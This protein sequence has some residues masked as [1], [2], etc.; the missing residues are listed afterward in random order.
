MK[1][2]N[3][4][5]VLC[6][7]FLI[8]ACDETSSTI[9]MD[10]VPDSDVVTIS[11]ENLDVELN[12]IYADSVL[13]RTSTCHLGNYTDPET[14]SVI[15]GDFLMQLNCGQNFEFPDSILYNTCSE[16]YLRLFFNDFVGDT[17]APCRVSIYPLTKVLDNSKAYYTDIDATEYYDVNAKPIVTTTFTMSDR[18][19][20]DSARYDADSYKNIRLKLP[21]EIGNDIIQKYKTHPE[22]FANGKVFNEKVNSGYFVKFERGDGVMMDIYVSQ[23]NLNYKYFEKSSTGRLDSLA[24]GSTTFAGTEE[25]IQATSIKKLN[26]DKLLKDESATYVKSPSSLFTEITLPIDEISISDTINSAKLIFDRF[27]AED[28]DADYTLPAPNYLLLVAKDKM[29]SFFEENSLPDSETSYLGTFST[30]NNNYVFSNIAHLLTKLRKE[31]QEGIKTN[32]NWVAE[33]P[34]WNKAV[35]IP[36]E[37]VY[38]TSGSTS[39]TS[40]YYS[41]YYGY[42]SSSTSS[43]LVGINHDLSLSSAR[44]KKNGIKIQLIYSKFAK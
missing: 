33:H 35:L 17:L 39:T 40:S 31:Y 27:N 1:I 10:L 32:P 29:Y 15:H 24:S 6:T 37:P 43:T 34:N 4:W 20:S 18:T 30:S 23:L 3:L 38:S 8:C 41:Y 21:N 42:S 26:L 19:I 7:A 22:Y 14:G 11:A 2:K 36:V 16:T 28:M 13:A 5:F 12:T 44:L 25:V 9:G